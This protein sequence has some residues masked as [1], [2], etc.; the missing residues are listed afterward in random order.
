M[1]L[2]A[3]F[4]ASIVLIIAIAVGS[5]VSAQQSQL[6][7]VVFPTSGSEKA[8]THFMRGLAALHSFWFEEALDEFRE[9]TKIEPTFV[10]GY[11][12]EA[13]SYNHPL[14][15]EQDTESARKTLTNIKD[16]SKVTSREQAYVEAVRLL[17]GEG[18]KL[19]RDKAY[20][21]AMEKVYKA[22]PDD[23]EAACFYSLSLLGT[24]RPGDKGY[25]RQA[26]AGAI[27]LD[28]YQKNPDHPGA[29]HY[30]I[31][32]FDDPEHAILALPAA[33]RYAQI[34]PE[35]HH[36]R[37]MPAHIFLQLGMW[38]EAA[39]SN[40]SAWA[41]SDAWVKR[42]NLALSLRDYH[43]LHWLAYVYMQ[44]GRYE[45]AQ[46][47]LPINR[48]DGVSRYNE[49]LTAAFVVETE[50]WDLASKY[51][52]DSPE[53]AAGDAGAH[54]QHGGAPAAT[55]TST[56]SRNQSLPSFVR[57]LAAAKIGAPE[58]AR[59]LAELQTI[60]KQISDRGDAYAAKSAEIRELEV[61]AL[62]AAS[63]QNY[64]EAI[65]MMKRATTIEEEMSPPS[66]P[67]TL[68]KPSH[69]LFGE[70]LLSAN[71]PKEAIAQFGTALLRQP[72]RARSLLGLARASAKS[73]DA[74]AALE[75]YSK[76]ATQW[77]QADS[78]LPELR[79]AQDYLKQAS[80][81]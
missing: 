71:R 44:Q 34:A 27:A 29:A 30:I 9:S 47:L 38:P 35:A 5:N 21:A 57:G 45:K 46:Q 72:N 59:F 24:V 26:I 60:R 36:A 74:K 56:R 67:P 70:I 28:V 54:A 75:A 23:L 1:K 11:W 53:Q 18:D 4:A 76:L 12:G 17:Y 41:V 64:T 52:N 79:E 61:S 40:E 81:R 73:G 66:G 68:I 7:K 20:C 39:A 55:P 33:R 63:K 10:M 31:H 50:R 49:D 62:I 2:S 19:Q 65:E 14:W 77:N 25:R 48:N 32:A 8:Q 37:H 13:M 6:G 80:A 3:C 22:Y 42:K 15:A 43:S 78:N 51:F 58:A 69:E 16:L